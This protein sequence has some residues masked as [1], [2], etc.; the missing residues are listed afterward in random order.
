MRYFVG[1]VKPALSRVLAS[2]GSR[3]R[4]GFCLSAVLRF[5][6][7]DASTKHLETQRILLR[8]LAWA[9]A[10]VSQPSVRRIILPPL[11]EWLKLFNGILILQNRI[12]VRLEALLKTIRI[13]R[14]YN[15]FLYPFCLTMNNDTF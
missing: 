14:P 3:S 1:D 9:V 2:V 15:Y 8:F 6:A 11:K 5:V 13:S 12:H 4:G 10:K 7:T